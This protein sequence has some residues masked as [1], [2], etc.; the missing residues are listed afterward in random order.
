MFCTAICKYYFCL[1][2][3]RVNS[4]FYKYMMSILCIISLRK[5]LHIPD[6]SAIIKYGFRNITTETA[7]KLYKEITIYGA[8]DLSPSQKRKE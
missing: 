1:R 4:V 5:L 3:L 2:S 6:E 7:K 8:A